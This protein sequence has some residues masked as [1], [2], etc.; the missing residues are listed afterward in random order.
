MNKILSSVFFFL[1]FNV[2]V[3]QINLPYFNDFE[4]EDSITWT[5]YSLHDDIK[6]WELG[7]PTSYILNK[8]S[9]GVK[10]W[11]TNINGR[12]TSTGRYYLETPDFNFSDSSNYV[13]SFTHSFHF[14][15][16]NWGYIEYSINEG[17][18]WQLL[19]DDLSEK[20]LWMYKH[21]N[22]GYYYGWSGLQS[23]RIHSSA[24][25]CTFLKGE[26]KVRF[27]FGV[28]ISPSSE[29]WLIDD[30]KISELERNY[31]GNNHPNNYITIN[32]T[33][34]IG[35]Y[36]FDYH[37]LV[38]DN[39]SRRKVNIYLSTEERF[40]I[41][42]SILLAESNS[43][44]NL[45]NKYS[46]PE[47]LN[48]GNY[49][50]HAFL[51]PDSIAFETNIDDNI[52]TMPF[53]VDTVYSL[54]YKDVF[55]NS[56]TF[57]KSM[58]QNFKED[59]VWFHG[60]HVLGSKY[61]GAN[62]RENIMY[63]DMTYY[64]KNESLSTLESPSLDLSGKDQKMVSI[65]FNY[66]P[67]IFEDKVSLGLNIK[68]SPTYPY[69]E[70]KFSY[71]FD[72]GYSLDLKN[73]NE[74]NHF[75]TLIDSTFYGENIKFYFKLYRASN[76]PNYIYGD[77]AIDD[78]YVGKPLADLLIIPQSEIFAYNDG[79]T[80]Q[81]PLIYKNNGLVD[82]EGFTTNFY[83]SND[84]KLDNTDSLLFSSSI[85][86]LLANE[87]KIDTL[88]I[89][90]PTDSIGVYYLISKIDPDNLVEEIWDRN[91]I[92]V[93]PVHINAIQKTPYSIDFEKE[94]EGW[95]HTSLFGK[96]DWEHAMSTEGELK[97]NKGKGLVTKPNGP[98]SSNSIM[99]LYTPTF[100]LSE[101]DNPVLEFDLLYDNYS[102]TIYTYNQPHL[103][104]SYSTDNGFTWSLLDTTNTSFKG[105]YYKS[106]FNSSNGKDYQ[107][108]YSISKI[109]Y[110]NQ[111]KSFINSR[112]YKTRDAINAEQQILDIAFLKGKRNVK[113]RYD[114]ITPE[115]SYSE[116][117]LID[118]FK[119]QEKWKNL[120]VSTNKTLYLSPK[121]DHI[122]LEFKIFNEG[123]YI[124]EK[125]DI[126]FYLAK[127]SILNNSALQLA[128]EMVPLIKPGS[129]EYFNLQFPIE[130][131]NLEDYS[132]IIYSIDDG[133]L[134]KETN[135]DD[136]IGVWPLNLSGILDYP[137]FNTFEDTVVN[138]WTGYSISSSGYKSHFRFRNLLA[139]HEYRQQ[140]G[141]RSGV[142]FAD[143]VKS[144]QSLTFVPT[145]Y[146]ETPNFNFS[147]KSKI[148]LSF[149]LACM[150]GPEMGGAIE[151][152]T[153]G[154]KNWQNLND[155]KGTALNWYNIKKID[156]INQSGWGD[157][158]FELLPRKIDISFLGGES[159]VMFR[160]IYRSSWKYWGAQVEKGIKIDNFKVEAFELDYELVADTDI[161]ETNI[162]NPELELEYSISNN[163][164]ISG[165]LINSYF[166]WSLD[167][168]L[169]ENDSLFYIQEINDVND[170][171]VNNFDITLKYPRDL[172]SLIYYLFIK[173]DGD[174]QYFELNEDNNLHKIKVIFDECINYSINDTPQV[175]SISPSDESLD[176]NYN[177]INNTSINGVPTNTSF[178]WSTDSIFDEND[179]LIIDFLEQ[180]VS[181]FSEINKTITIPNLKNI[182][183]EKHY[184]F[185]KIDA[186]DQLIEQKENDNIGSIQILYELPD[187]TLLDDSRDLFMKSHESFTLPVSIS[188]QGK[189][190]GNSVDVSVYLSSNLNFYKRLKIE[191][192]NFNRVEEGEA[193]DTVLVIDQPFELLYDK[194]YILY[195]IDE[196]K[197][198]LESNNLNNIGVDTIHVEYPNIIL[199]KV[200]SVD[201][202]L[203][204]S[205]LI[206][207]EIFNKSDFQ[208]DSIDISFFSS[209]DTLINSYELPLKKINVQIKSNE[210]ISGKVSIP[211]PIYENTSSFYLKTKV[212]YD[213]KIYEI[214]KVDNYKF[215]KLNLGYPNYKYINEV[216]E[217]YPQD[218][219]N[220]I[221]IEIPITNN[222]HY[223]GD[224][225]IDI[226]ISW[227][228]YKDQYY[229]DLKQDKIS[230]IAVNDTTIYHLT[231]NY[232]ESG[233]SSYY[234]RYS[235][236]ENKRIFG[237]TLTDNLGYIRVYKELVNFYISEFE[238][239]A[240]KN[241][242]NSISIP[243]TVNREYH[244]PFIMDTISTHF[245]LS[246]D[247]IYDD[248]D[249][250]IIANDRVNF[251]QYKSS[252]SDTINIQ[253]PTSSIENDY[254]V[255]YK[256]NDD[257][258]RLESNY[259]D[260]TGYIN[261][262]IESVLTSLDDAKY[263]SNQIFLFDRYLNINLY[264]N[265][266]Q[267]LFDIKLI[268]VS[269]QEVFS[270]LDQDLTSQSKF[271]IPQ[272]IPNGIYTV[273][274]KNNSTKKVLVE[275]IG[276]F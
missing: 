102:N 254:Y 209:R 104:L 22:N 236:D 27:R 91:N 115:F 202:I 125:T 145:N 78:F 76:Y 86:S 110:Q 120:K 32:D 207:Y 1:L 46:L 13:L 142:M 276:I 262:A 260:N 199:N 69:E 149:E 62:S 87:N 178:Y 88:L 108:G 17:E 188:N 103:N 201:S 55:Q 238:D 126:K 26:D 100:D 61:V 264:E 122:D 243:Y 21:S 138:G 156:G 111:E 99:R 215:L 154:G 97:W 270:I 58:N 225:S 198:I 118:N 132:Y 6:V 106:Y 85:E 265:D 136:N 257:N 80:H 129:Q 192:L 229:H 161:I 216:I 163:G 223:I 54:P 95:Y 275:K 141:L 41:N 152:S 203:G 63:T 158:Q 137:Y 51:I 101:I 146:L 184:I 162:E 40:D 43:I 143:Q 57:W 186:S 208:Y 247:S 14:Y 105:W 39:S 56:D 135:E 7:T 74:W 197:T 233:R 251:L 116:G 194:Y 204:D 89:D 44:K 193:I 49:Y 226:N 256:I 200:S 45:K 253:L 23:D 179:T 112:D 166:Y 127:D 133:N 28:N 16:T 175:K 121:T 65:Y 36:S 160:F 171:K 213:N 222:G 98:V 244:N 134:V 50:L 177:I 123:N 261:I 271:L 269:G 250:L 92:L 11:G 235:L 255:I 240:V 180:E 75:S 59:S 19:L 196:D 159:S 72:K 164:N 172:D 47:K 83:W 189:A 242:Q 245:Y 227:S 2:S 24:Y 231:F 139:P 12:P 117:A 130:G 176:I 35:S 273:I 147:E 119:I 191:N 210:V 268:N 60:D 128:V 150:G 185:Y 249:Q 267:G 64:S 25:N 79:S 181:S 155:K 205:L 73:N 144:E 77:V 71:K 190:D 48:V 34:I 94:T 170:L 8:H 52:S 140:S 266:H 206:N 29:G 96:D 252:L 218:I 82:A 169:D 232:P 248:S 30:F 174:N 241:N 42:K 68:K 182:T 53:S 237:D 37:G 165:G 109:H 183:Q 187:L 239:I 18:S 224:D 93:T 221:D 259:S 214:D 9:S 66:Q 211:R 81:V 107:D 31:E 167:E 217:V 20:N 157:Y 230:R 219:N 168:T 263:N 274:L 153:D 131:I 148:I 272:K 212:N 33:S 3:A 10:A 4:E 220:P 70:Y 234:I 15:V 173:I 113:F 246:L 114:F 90:L 5:S 67:G 228:G 195:I 258:N 124:T 151:Y 84:D 38:G